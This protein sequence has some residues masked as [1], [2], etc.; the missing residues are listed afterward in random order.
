MR[1]HAPFLCLLTASALLAADITAWDLYQQGRE[2][3]KHGHMA[4]AYLLYSRA[5]GM[6]PQNRTYWLRSQSVKTRAALEA[7]VAPDAAITEE[8]PG[9]DAPDDA[10]IPEA[11][12]EDRAQARR[13]LPPAELIAD[14]GTRD[15]DL[16]EDSKKLY[17]DVAKAFG[18]DC[19]FD[20]DYQPLPPLHF[21]LHDVDYRVALRG[22]EAATNTFL[23]PLSSNLF[24]VAKDTPQKRAELEPRASLS[25]ELPETSTPQ[26]FNAVVTA[27]QQAAGIEKIAFDSAEHMVI[28]RDTAAK[29]LAARSL[30]EDLMRPRAQLMLDIKLL[31]VTRN[32]MLTYGIDFPTLFSLTP[33]TTWFRNTVSE[34]QDV[35]GLLAFGGG[36]TLMGI[37][38]LTPSLV[39]QLSKATGANLQDSQL[40][41]NDGAPAT[42]HMGTQYPVLTAGYYGP[43]NFYGAG[44]NAGVGASTGN[45]NANT[46]KGT[47]SLSE[48]AISWTYATNGSLPESASVTV[49]ST[50]GAM[51]FTASVA[52]S[53]PWL[54]VNGA[55]AASGALPATLSI[56]PGTALASLGTGSYT[57]TV[58]IYAADGS[59]ASI[60]VNLEVNGGAAGLTVSPNPIALST[61]V[62][63]LSVQQ[64]VTVTSSLAG[65]LTATVSGA[66]L[67]ISNSTTTVEANTPANFVVL[68][69]PSGLAGQAYAGV[70]TV[71]VGDMTVETP[72]T[73]TVV[74]TGTWQLSQ[75]S[76]SWTYSSGG[77]APAAVSIT[78]SSY[79]GAA[80]F[81][82]TASSPNA[83]LLVNGST[84]ASGML[85]GVL[86]ISPSTNIALLGTGSY[87]GTVQLTSSDGSI[88]YITVSLTV[89]GGF[90][91]GLKVSPD[92]VTISIPAGGSTAQQTVTVTS[93]TAGTLSAT[94]SGSGLS[95]SLDTTTVEANT[96][97]TLTLFANPSGLSSATY[98]GSLNV[99]VAGV[100]Q[101]VQ[102]NFSVGVVSTGTNGTTAYTPPPSF[103]YVD[104]G[105]SLKVTPRVHNL[106][107]VTLDLDAAFKVLSGQA[108]NGIPIIANREFK[109]NVRLHMGEW[110][111]VAGLLDATEAKNVAGLAGLTRIPYLGPLTSVHTNTKNMDEVLILVRPRLITLPPGA[112]VAIRGYRMGSETK[113]ITPL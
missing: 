72:V 44:G 94:V 48:S 101:T 7:A 75:S 46:G 51:A 92:P 22:L 49:S 113:P 38:V 102:V 11:T 3:E 70:V 31:E 107:E 24:L 67:S 88:T 33:L 40:R 64:I 13:T 84:S 53:S 97:V 57:G 32:N 90:A 15:F 27:V 103:T 110:A 60:A 112:G 87:T 58:Q 104:L 79:T 45:G 111:A 73:F 105:L 85:P 66:G 19:V 55:A 10:E 37:G 8:F 109:S 39:A 35:A 68:G 26:E 81:T 106:D 47:L 52:S 95:I 96:P 5:A 6:E 28:L 17:E 42:M 25:I 77:D 14:P 2:A 59:V 76:I 80:S 43:S 71:T 9:I 100:T 91:T 1:I 18:L 54:Q 56:S 99:T 30:I 20:A 82:A 16:H 86:T 62:G 29:I 61:T 41:T 78:A 69:N 83:W 65:T 34:P 12:P 36:N 108:L 21:E 4:Q 93:A 23:V 89:N 74:S 63:G 50:K 98:I